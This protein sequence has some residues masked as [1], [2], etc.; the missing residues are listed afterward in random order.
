MLVVGATTI[1]AIAIGSLSVIAWSGSSLTHDA[2]ALEAA[3]PSGSLATPEMPAP[4]TGKPDLTTQTVHQV[5]L[6][7]AASV[8]PGLPDQES[9]T[10]RSAT[11]ELR[12][13]W[14]SVVDGCPSGNGNVR[15]ANARSALE[16]LLTFDADGNEIGRAPSGRRGTPPGLGACFISRD[17]LR[18]RV[19]APGREVQVLVRAPI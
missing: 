4:P 9:G 15:D 10:A 2:P 16:F 6:R 14:P 19:P 1:A 18:M 5:A 13:L 11:D 7:A 8:A 17:D 12:R 3:G